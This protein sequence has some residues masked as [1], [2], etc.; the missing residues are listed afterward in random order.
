M[1]GEPPLS[2]EW[3]QKPAQA[4]DNWRTCSQ[5]REQPGPWCRLQVAGARGAVW[6][7][8]PLQGATS[9]WGL[10]KTHQ[11]EA[12]WEGRQSGGEGGCVWPWQGQEGQGE[13]DPWD[14]GTVRSRTGAPTPGSRGGKEAT[15]T[16]WGNHVHGFYKAYWPG[17][18]PT[19]KA[20]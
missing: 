2:Q 12:S 16:V 5:Q 8:S 10:R 20:V 17:R 4:G 15:H 11:R 13:P 7:R 14:G 18:G 19:G 3:V 6:G 9:R 1:V